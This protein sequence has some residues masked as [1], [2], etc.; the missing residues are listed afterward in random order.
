MSLNKLTFGKDW[1][2][3]LDF[4]T[5]EVSEEQVRADLQY[6]PDQIRDF[7][8]DEL[9]AALEEN[10]VL[11]ITRTDGA[12]MKYIRLNADRV[13]ETSLDGVEW[14][15]TGSSGHVIVAP[16]GTV[17]EPFHHDMQLEKEACMA[18]N[19]RVLFKVKA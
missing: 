9:I 2:S 5:Y 17:F 3:A 11:E 14:E 1:T 12:T 18:R 13:L 6:H 7:L 16:D 8:N 15:A 10:G 4:P 19:R